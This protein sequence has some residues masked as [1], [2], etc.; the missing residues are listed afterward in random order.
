MDQ[1]ASAFNATSVAVEDLMVRL[2]LDFAPSAYAFLFPP[3]SEQFK[4]AD[5]DSFA[6]QGVFPSFKS[7][8]PAFVCCALFSFFRFVFHHLFFKRLAYA[9]M[10]IKS[11][12]L[13]PNPDLDRNLPSINKKKPAEEKVLEYCQRKKLNSHD[14]NAYL[15]S[16]YKNECNERSVSKF[17]EAFWRCLFY[18]VFVIVAYYTFLNPPQPWVEDLR[19][20][21]DKWPFHTVIPALLTY[22][23]VQ[24]GCYLHQLLW[25]EVSRSDAF[26]M[27]L[28][29]IVTI[30]LIT[31]SYV[32]NLQR[33]GKYL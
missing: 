1:F 17:V 10:N 12:P 5:V 31:T 32:I 21:W 14:V 23:H 24:L 15:R 27:I 29:H 30:F 4:I 2:G 7:L 3:D 6:A 11:E 20:C 8:A 18:T 13:V 9:A 19:G 26:E 33:I 25:T 28:H 16:R 22:H